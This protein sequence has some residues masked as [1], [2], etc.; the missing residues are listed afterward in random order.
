[1]KES[2]VKKHI[3]T[4]LSLQEEFFGWV[5]TTTGIWDPKTERFRKRSGT[6]MRCGVAD[7][8]GIWCGRGIALEIKTEKGRLT[9]G[10]IIFL[11]D[12]KNNGGIAAVLRSLKDTDLLLEELRTKPNLHLLSI[13][14]PP[15]LSAK[16]TPFL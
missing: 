1:M 13:G 9:D 6:G 3:F 5:E 15:Q 2:I 12:F 10:Q 16:L 8:V 11:A 4:L 7:I 14:Y